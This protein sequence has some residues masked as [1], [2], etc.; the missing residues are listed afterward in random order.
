MKNI[1]VNMSE[2]VLNKIKET[3]TISQTNKDTPIG[4]QLTDIVDTY[5]RIINCGLS[6]FNGKLTWNEVQYMLASINGTFFPNTE[7]AFTIDCFV[8][9]LVDFEVYE[10]EQ[11]EQFGIS[12]KELVAKLQKEHHISLFALLS[13]LH[14]CWVVDGYNSDFKAYVEQHL[15]LKA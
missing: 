11:A 13:L 12:A 10:K 7:I 14:Q 15:Q 4:Y 8:A 1:E 9:E 2:A 6:D 5:A 3:I